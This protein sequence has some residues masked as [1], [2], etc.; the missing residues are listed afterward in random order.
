METIYKVNI[1]KNK[2]QI[3]NILVFDGSIT[4]NM[5]N[6]NYSNYFNKEELKKIQNENIEI[7]LINEYIFND[8]SIGN[9]K[10][11][12]AKALKNIS[13]EEIY[14]FCLK[15]EIINPI[16]IY[17]NLTQNEKLLLTKNRLYHLLF[18]LY[19][20]N[21]KLVNFYI[22]EKELYDYQDI[23]NLNLNNVKNPYLVGKV[24]GQKFIFNNEYIFIANPFIFED[25]DKL[26]ENSKNELSSL[27]NNLLLETGIISNNNIY[28]CLAKDVY[29]YYEEKDKSINYFAKIYFPFLNKLGILTSEELEKR[30]INLINETNRKIESS[31]ENFNTTSMFYNIFYNN[32]Q[33]EVFSI[34]AKNTGI[35]NF[36]IIKNY[37]FKIKFPIE[38][39]FKIINANINIPLIKYNP[40]TRQ[41]NIYRLYTDKLTS[42]NR[43]IPYL[44][45][46]QILKLVKNIG[47]SKSV[48]VYN[49]I[50][51]SNIIYNIIIEFKENG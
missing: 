6:I 1:L 24:L 33:S 44:S 20:S 4:L 26:L 15:K 42:D 19:N 43:K 45:K 50:E 28:C 35:K 46:A 38:I 16:T 22:N 41:E 32:K 2:N 39:I 18:N 11:K 23:L 17:Q 36:R 27:N 37:P 51:I 34:I 5:N 12:I 25:Y 8:D 48:S 9:I 47:K 14:L 40:E 21:E 49:S 29:K 13:F 31:N 3:V 10:L 7:N 30:K